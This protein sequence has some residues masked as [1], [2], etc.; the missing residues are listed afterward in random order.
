MRYIARHLEPEIKKAARHFPVVILTG[1]RRSGKTTML[2]HSFPKAAYHLLEDPD[3]V[4][5]VRGDPRSFLDSVRLPAILDEIQNAPELLNYIR[6]R[7]DLAGSRRAG[8]LLTGSQEPALMKGVTESMAGRAAI[9][10]LLP[11]SLAESPRVSM[12]RGG[13]PEVLAAPSV[14]DVW[15]RSYLQTYLERDIRAI[16]SIRDLTAFRKFLALVASRVGG[17]L[18][19]TDLAAPLGISV[20]TVSEWLGLLEA[21]HQLLLVPPYFEN[22]GKRLI[23]SPK[24]YFADTGLAAHLLGLESEAALSASPFRGPIF[25]NYVASEIVKAQVNAGKRRELYYFRDRQGLEVDFLV[26]RGGGR[27]L[28]LEA[29]ASRTITPA[30]ADAMVRLQKAVG[31]RAAEAAV[32]HLPSEAL[33]N[34]PAGRE[35][36]RA[37]SCED[38]AELVG[39]S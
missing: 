22:F 10:Q 19:R 28:L 9:F 37:V 16:S 27:L 29:K 12:W 1:P 17:V 11:L 38:V 4:G 8:W 35:G 30:D 31:P 25:E 7:A 36:V 13:F 6:S 23:K 24:V 5:R 39:E 20:P 15:F 14:A 18:N 34:S 3:L 33:R 21:T 2:R 26:P 32:V